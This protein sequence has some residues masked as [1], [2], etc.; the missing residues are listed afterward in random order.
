MRSLF[1]VLSSLVFC[2]ACGRPSYIS[3][4]VYPAEE[5]TKAYKNGTVQEYSYHRAA[6]AHSKGRGV[7][8]DDPRIVGDLPQGHAQPAAYGT[9]QAPLG[10]AL[11]PSAHPAARAQFQGDP[12]LL[13]QGFELKKSFGPPPAPQQFHEGGAAHPGSR[14]NLGQFPVPPT[15]AAAVPYAGMPPALPPGSS[16]PYYNGQ[17]TANPS[18]WPDE[19]QGAFLFNDYRASQ[20]MDIITIVIDENNRGTKKAETETESEFDLIAG[21]TEFFGI[22][23]TKWLANN[24]SLDPTQLINASTNTEY[25]GEGE[26]EREGRL[27]GKISAVIMEKLP[28]GLLRVEGTKIISLNE[29]E[30]VLVISGLVRQRDISAVNEVQSSRVANVR[31]DFYGRGVIGEQQKPGWASRI[32]ELVWPF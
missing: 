27:T 13:N 10:G 16:A 7:P 4:D 26:T 5:F 2:L 21:I 22:E 31:I 3:R 6:Q 17:M 30:E 25:S 9:T 1:L 14:A 20:A 32:F 28:N 24:T 29:E 19:A 8:L 12:K 23:T 15:A 11:P 18:L